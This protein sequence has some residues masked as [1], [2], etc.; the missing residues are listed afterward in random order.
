MSITVLRKLDDENVPSILQDCSKSLNGT[1]EEVV[2][3]FSSVHRLNGSALRSLQEFAT[4]AKA[5]SV[6]VTLRA[7][8]AEVYKV[9][10]L[11]K[12]TSRFRFAN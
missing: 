10:V 9:L 4:K 3:D 1:Q 5:D 6:K 8:N 2:I 11:M 7:V 12:L